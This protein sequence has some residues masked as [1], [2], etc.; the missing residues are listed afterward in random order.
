MLRL[1]L[2][3]VLCTITMGCQ[4]TP[5][6]QRVDDTT[7]VLVWTD[8]DDPLAG[9]VLRLG[10]QLVIWSSFPNGG[11]GS[12]SSNMQGVSYRGWLKTPRDERLA[13]HYEWAAGTGGQVE[14]DGQSYEL[15]AGRLFLIAAAEHGYRVRQL[16]RD[17]ANLPNDRSGMLQL[18]GSD[19]EIREFFSNSV[20]VN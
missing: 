7:S 10:N 20:A 4:P 5:S 3:A 13:F 8:V 9:T 2:I 16:D 15:T 6:T 1:T 17:L 14:I 11:S 18:S 12:S 19:Q